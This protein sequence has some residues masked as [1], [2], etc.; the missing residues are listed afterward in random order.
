LLEVST[1]N[2]KQLAAGVKAWCLLKTP[3]FDGDH[4]ESQ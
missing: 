2:L 1:G 3:C 4:C